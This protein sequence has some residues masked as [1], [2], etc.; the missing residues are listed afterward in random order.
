M[1]VSEGEAAE[2]GDRNR[3]GYYP[4]G[5]NVP[6]KKIGMLAPPLT[7]LRTAMAMLV[8]GALAVGYGFAGG[9][10]LTLGYLECRQERA[11]GGVGRLWRA[12]AA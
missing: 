5:T 10:D 2:A 6:T 4:N 7:L 12:R 8:A 3:A 1:Q 9:P 11:G